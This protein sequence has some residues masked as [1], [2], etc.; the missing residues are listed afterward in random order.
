MAMEEDNEASQMSSLSDDQLSLD[1]SDGFQ[2]NHQFGL[3][4]IDEEGYE[5]IDIHNMDIDE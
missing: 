4:E 2:V 3:K 1:K 5:D